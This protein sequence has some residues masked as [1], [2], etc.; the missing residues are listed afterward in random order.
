[1]ATNCWPSAS[2]WLAPLLAGVSASKVFGA[3]DYLP[4]QDWSQTDKLSAQ[5]DQIHF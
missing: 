3:D 2:F 5:R 4:K 1:M